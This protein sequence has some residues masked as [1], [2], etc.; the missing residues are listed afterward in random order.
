MTKVV[1]DIKN[2]PIGARFFVDFREKPS[3][4]AMLVE[5]YDI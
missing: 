3:N 4:L 5:K 2:A 1:P